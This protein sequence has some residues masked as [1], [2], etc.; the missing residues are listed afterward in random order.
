MEGGAVIDLRLRPDAPAV[1]VDDPVDRGQADAGPGKIRRA[2]QTSKR[3]KQSD[4]IGHVKTGPMIAYVE[5]GNIIVDV[6]AKFN[7][8][9]AGIAGEFPGIDNSHL[10]VDRQQAGSRT[11]AI[12]R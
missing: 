11:H 4:G 10:E 6:M 2:V 9:L 8:G 7:T 12:G 3:G 1:A 5:Y